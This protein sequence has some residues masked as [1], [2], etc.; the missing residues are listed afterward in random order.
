MLLPINMWFLYEEHPTFSYCSSVKRGQRQNFEKKKKRVRY[1]EQLAECSC[2]SR[3]KG[4][5]DY[6]ED[7]LKF[8][9]DLT[10][11]ASLSYE[12]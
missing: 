10:S 8:Q 11:L 1:E 3:L 6:L 5:F 9:R 7:R 12:R 4:S 2:K